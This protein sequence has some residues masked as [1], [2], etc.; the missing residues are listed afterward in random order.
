MLCE[1]RVPASTG[2]AQALLP[3]LLAG[4]ELQGNALRCRNVLI[5]IPPLA[6]VD[7]CSQCQIDMHYK[8]SQS[9]VGYL[10]IRFQNTSRSDENDR[11]E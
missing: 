5:V 10:R 9:Q 6:D 2:P 1:C 3:W 8:Q 4:S 11:K 7:A